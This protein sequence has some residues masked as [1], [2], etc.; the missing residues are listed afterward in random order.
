[1]WSTVLGVV[2]IAALGA[3]L[4]QNFQKTRARKKTN[5]EALFSDVPNVI[6]EPVFEHQDYHGYPRLSGRYGG[7][8]VQINP[9]ADTL[10]I[11]RLPALWL[12]V[13]VQDRLPVKARFDMMMRP[14]GPT[15]FSNFELL[16]RTLEHPEGFPE[17]AVIRTD[18]PIGIETYWHRRFES[19]RKNGE[20]FELTA[21]DVKAF[22]RRKFM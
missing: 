12:L 17:H 6:E 19:K 9:V 2:A 16:P 18:D 14:A 20:W 10:A 3:R 8:P 21:Q 22:K 5:I 1:M 11:R 7:F 15:T 13:T 4:V